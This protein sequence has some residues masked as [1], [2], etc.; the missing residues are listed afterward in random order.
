MYAERPLTHLPGL[1]WELTASDPYLVL[2]D[3]CTDVIWMRGRL[4]VAGP[5]TRATPEPA[6]G[7]G[8][9]GLRFAPGTGPAVFGVAACELR[10][11]RVPLHDL[12]PE[13]Q[14]RELE[15]LLAAGTPAA[16]LLEDAA[17]RHAQ[18]RG[19][20]DGASR[21]V[22]GE[23]ARGAPVAEIA[24]RLGITERHLYRRCLE[25]FGYGAKTL[26]RILRLQRALTLVRSGSPAAIAALDAGYADQTHLAHDVR[27]L[28]GVP[29]RGL[30]GS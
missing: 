2:P 4:V 21:W 28:T 27:A 3:G 23:L 19:G 12:W 20:G 30:L 15:E 16:P 26:Q 13:S 14:V 5:D 18:A 10:D 29:L 1:A 9:V 7:A 25:A 11:T 8:V 22:A 6:T 24:R 17:A